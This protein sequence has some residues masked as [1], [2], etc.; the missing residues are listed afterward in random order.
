M[1]YW[2]RCDQLQTLPHFLQ[3]FSRRDPMAVAAAAAAA[4]AALTPPASSY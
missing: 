4:A 1:K 3:S 2:L